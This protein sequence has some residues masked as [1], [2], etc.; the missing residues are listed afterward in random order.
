MPI[1][2]CVVG[3]GY[4]G[5]PLACLLSRNFSVTGFDIIE[6]K[7]NDLR[8]G[9]DETGE[10]EDLKSFK[11]DFST[12][13]KIIGAANFIIVAVPTPVKSNLEPDLTMVKSA[14]EI[15]G[16]NIKKG[17]TVVFESTVYPGC[18]EEICL[19]IIEQESGLKAGVDFLYGYSPERVNPG[20]KVH[21]IDK[22][23][24][25]ISGN[26]NEALDK[27]EEVYGSVTKV[28]RA[29]NIKTAEAAKV[30]ENV[31]RDL[32]I[33]LIN[34]L[35]LIFDKIGIDTKE[36]IEAA[37]TKWN[38]HKYTPGLVGGHCIGVDPYYLTYKAK[39]LGYDAKIILAG[40]D[41]NEYMV[42]FIA[43]KLRGKSKVLVLGVTFKENVPD[44]RNSKVRDLINKLKS[45]GSEVVIHDPIVK[46]IEAFE[47]E[48]KTSLTYDLSVVSDFDAIVVAS[49]HAIFSQDE[50]SLS[51]L[52][53][54]C[55]INP[56]LFDVKGF[57]SREEAENL[58]FTYLTL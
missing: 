32:N 33:A 25:I 58:G 24:K 17:S 35:A 40:R 55:R 53:N 51:N 38:F 19:P 46:N 31:Q 41:V 11:I 4:V 29:S 47:K 39:K 9:F 15:V 57:Y 50:Y 36:V 21:T 14:S 13:T 45:F 42:D 26:N 44:I 16:K 27:L 52:F 18:T 56:I 54:R 48:F 34:E 22:V 1:K 28:Y 8:N 30:I 37:G 10:V 20:D 49:P 6:R 2:I 12:D 23:V 43:D 3:L 7:V 5:L